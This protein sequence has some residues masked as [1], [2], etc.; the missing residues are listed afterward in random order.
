MDIQTIIQKNYNDLTKKQ[1]QIADYLMANPAEICYI[2]LASLS[3]QIGCTELTV[4]KFCHTLGFTGFLDLKDAFREYNRTMEESLS[5]STFSVQP[6]S[7][8]GSVAKC[9]ESLRDT[10]LRNITE[11]YREADLAEFAAVAESLMDKRIL[12]IFAHDVSRILG[13][14]LQQRLQIMKF[15]A[16]LVDLSDMRRLETVFKNMDSKD[17]VILFSFPKYLFSVEEIARIAA[18]KCGNIT[19]LTD[20]QDSPAAAYATHSIFCKTETDF[21]N[22]FWLPPLAAVSLLTSHLAQC[23]SQEA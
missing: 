8:G 9:L 23:L 7:P 16:V 19:L 21:F 13:A 20:R 10:Q 18:Q 11:F 2:S 12:Y 5:R 3:K 4:L 22:N 15:N 14:Y 17:A 6:S 1:R